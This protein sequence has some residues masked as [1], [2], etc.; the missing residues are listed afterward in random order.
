[1]AAKELDNLNVVK[2]DAMRSC[3]NISVPGSQS[4]LL[5]VQGWSKNFI[6]KQI[7]VISFFNVIALQLFY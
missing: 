3:S 4:G 6:L 7:A 5:L 2:K 1:M